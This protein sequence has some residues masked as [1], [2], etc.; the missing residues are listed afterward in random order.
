MSFTSACAM[1]KSGLALSSTITRI[2]SSAAS[3][4]PARIRSPMSWASNRLIGG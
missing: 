4:A 3:A 2:A 1:K